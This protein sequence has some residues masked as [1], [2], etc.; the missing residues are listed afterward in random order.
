MRRALATVAAATALAG[1]LAGCATTREKAAKV[2]ASGNAAFRAEGLDVR[3]ANRDVEVVSTSVVSD[4]N[5]T[6]VVAV[7]R[8]RGRAALVDVP[9][10]LSVTDRD[11]RVVARNDE[12]GLEHGLTHAALLPKDGTVTWVHDQVIASGPGRPARAQVTPGRAAAAPA[13]ASAVKL[14]FSDHRVVGDPAS[15]VNATGHVV[16]R[17][18][19][20]QRDLVIVCVAR[21]GGSVVAA[22]RGIVPVLKPGRRARFQV[23]FIGD[24]SGA[25]LTFEA[26]PS[27]LERAT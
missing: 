24:P 16:N 6:A 3:R 12:A 14:D 15:G 13:G 4:A 21:K 11:G 1:G 25:E 17:S 26:Q 7:L 23:Y 9:L 18:D 2:A 19:V 8:N 20:E 27:N 22:G 5:G 10:A